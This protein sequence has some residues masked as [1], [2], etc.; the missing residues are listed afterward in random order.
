LGALKIKRLKRLRRKYTGEWVNDKR[1]GRGTMFFDNED[2]YDGFWKDDVPHGEGRM[3]YN[4]G[5][6]YEG[7]WYMGKRC[8]YGVLTKRNKDHF[9]GHWVNDKR[10]RTL[11]WDIYFWLQTVSKLKGRARQLL[12]CEQKQSVRW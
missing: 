1:E 3:I 8:G 9:E 2:R 7:M 4:N 5:D 11:T 12:F 6:V 10:V